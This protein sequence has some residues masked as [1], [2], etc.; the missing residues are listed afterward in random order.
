MKRISILTGAAMLL[1][2]TSAFAAETVKVTVGHMCCGSCK[3]AATA[4]LKTVPWA[5][6]V[7]IDGTVATVVAKGDQKVDVVSLRDALAKA[8]FPA[9][10]ILVSGPVT[11]SV[12]HMCCA[13][14]ANDLKT[15]LAAIRGDR[16]DKEHIT[17]DQAAKT[18]TVQPAAG[19]TMNLIQ[20]LRQMENAG[21]SATKCTITTA[22]T[23]KVIRAVATR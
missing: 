4:G 21:Y 2:A 17:V 10:E 9:K 13:G 5:D 6:S 14:C 18:V 19:M 23:K 7:T 15:G 11:M 20:V 12:T 1:L 3:A 22:S 8:G 16:F